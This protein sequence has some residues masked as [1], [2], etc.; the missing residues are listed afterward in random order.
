MLVAKPRLRLRS[1]LTSRTSEPRWVAARRG[2][3]PRVQPASGA[4]TR[5][6][7]GDRGGRASRWRPVAR[8]SPAG[9]VQVAADLLGTDQAGKVVDGCDVA[10]SARVHELGTVVGQ[11]VVGVAAVELVQ[12]G[13]RLPD[14]DQL[15]PSPRYQ[16][17]SL[18]DGGVHRQISSHFRLHPTC[19]EAARCIVVPT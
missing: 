3:R 4:G 1:R 12:L 15:H 7:E 11:D 18:C 5:S 16:H 8:S 10:E 2:V 17:G 6:E 13:L 9:L 19:I 14:R